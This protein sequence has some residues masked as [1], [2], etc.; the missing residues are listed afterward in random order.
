MSEQ[1]NVMVQKHRNNCSREYHL[2]T[3]I[4]DTSI[5]NFRFPATDEEISFSG[6]GR[7]GENIAKHLNGVELMYGKTV[8]VNE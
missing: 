7:I 4:S 8:V 3:R 6:V 1:L 2:K 5:Y